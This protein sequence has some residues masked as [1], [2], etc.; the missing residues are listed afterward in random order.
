MRLK[1]RISLIATGV[2]IFVIFTPAIVLFA[3]GFRYDFENNR[4]LKTGTIAIRTEPRQVEVSINGEK[5]PNLTPFAKRFLLPGEYTIEIFKPGY[6]A[7]KKKITVQE[8]RVSFLP[9]NERDKIF[10]FKSTLIQTSLATNTS[11]FIEKDSNIYYVDKNDIFRISQTGEKPT[12]QATIASKLENPKILDVNV[13]PEG[14]PSFLIKDAAKNYYVARKQS[15]E[16]GSDLKSLHFT[17]SSNILAINGQDQLIEFLPT[18]SQSLIDENVLAFLSEDNLYFLSKNS[19]GNLQ[20]WIMSANGNATLL[21]DNLPP[22]SSAEIIASDSNQ[23]FLLL[24]RDLYLISDNLQKLNSGTNYA[25]WSDQADHLIYGNEHEIWLYRPT[26]DVNGHLITRT[27]RSLGTATHNQET[28]YI[29]VGEENEIKAIEF[30][31]S[32]QPNVY[33]FDETKNPISKLNV[34]PEGT[35]IIYLDGSNLYSLKIR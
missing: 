26:R 17:S 5:Q 29:F 25:S 12:L 27:T 8:E 28:G 3:T 4:L 13:S 22:A 19:L 10:L 32:G 1:T 23:I 7:W 11:D 33:V 34:N 15:I 35:H 24:D 20:L 21:R 14:N 6:R 9:S 30:D 31:S 2:L 18:Q 16:L